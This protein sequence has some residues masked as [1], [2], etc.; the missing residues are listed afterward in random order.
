MTR[1][2]DRDLIAKL[3]AKLA[4]AALRGDLTAAELAAQFKQIEEWIKARERNPEVALTLF[5]SGPGSGET[6]CLPPLPAPRH[7]P[8]PPHR[9]RAPTL[10]ASPALRHPPPNRSRTPT[11]PASP[12]LRHPA[13]NRPRAPTL[14]GSLAIRHSPV[15]PQPAVLS[16]PWTLP[17]LPVTLRKAPTVP[18]A[19]RLREPP[20]LP[21]QAAAR[22]DSPLPPDVAAEDTFDDDFWEEKARQ[23]LAFSAAGPVAAGAPAPARKRRSR[24]W[25]R[26][27]LGPLFLGWRERHHAAK[28]SRQ[29][30]RLYEKVAAAYP[31]LGR[32]ELYHRIVMV[33]LDA[34][35][36]EA[37][38]VLD[39]AAESFAM[40]P[41]ERDL[42]FRDVVHY[43]AVSDYLGPDDELAAWTRE[44]LGRV[45]ASLVSDDL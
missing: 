15:P 43:L 8:A 45:V 17:A 7:P 27:L 6:P 30:L 4:S 33:R 44:N 28:I 40:W 34:D 3:K 10:P 25:M 32:Q 29:L 23:A 12:E 38:E 9:S 22:L 14:P 19:P 13:P 26:R 31:R 24:G 36:S 2:A 18:A 37:Y 20:A 21:P 16:K 11:L 35:P 41:V 39:R 1:E 5:H 42:I